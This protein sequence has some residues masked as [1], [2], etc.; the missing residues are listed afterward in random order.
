M[1][2]SSQFGFGLELVSDLWVPGAVGV[3]PRGNAPSV[4]IAISDACAVDPD[5]QFVCEGAAIVYRHPTGV[6][7]CLPDNIE[8]APCE[9]LD[10]DD[11]GMLLVANA[12]PAVLWQ[13]GA[14]VLHA[15]CV[16]LPDG[17]TIAIAGPS[18]AGKSRLA[19]SF[20][21]AG[22]ELIGDDSLALAANEDGVLASGLPGGWFSRD[23]DSPHR[24]F[25]SNPG[26]PSG[27]MARLDVLAV[28]DE[29]D[30]VKAGHSP[31]ASFEMLMQNRHRPQVPLLL[32]LQG[33]VLAHAARIVQRLPVVRLA[34]GLGSIEDLASTRTA[35]DRLA[36]EARYVR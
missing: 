31:L 19:A 17:L 36:R 11:L 7:R 9:P 20:V 23:K 14:F 8:I 12:L 6:F 15:A 18:G 5:V 29:A 30:P 28:L 33:Q 21:E 3:A 26:G 1:Q 4:R 10:L 22:A 2:I 34:A 27:G 24:E 35:L 32:G 16:R 25:R 13:R